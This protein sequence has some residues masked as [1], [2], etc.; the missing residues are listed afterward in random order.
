LLIFIKT[1]SREIGKVNYRIKVIDDHPQNFPNGS[2]KFINLSQRT[3][4]LI[5]GQ[6]DELK[7]SMKPGGIVSHQLPKSFKGNLPVKIALKTAKGAV[8]VMNSRV[9]PNHHVRDLYFIWP[10]PNKKAGHKVQISTL[11]E[12]GDV[13]RMRLKGSD[14]MAGE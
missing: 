14:K 2:M 5:A 13:A 7:K 4:Y 12:R 11:R 3:L 9:F 8:P 10:I 6:N 1:R